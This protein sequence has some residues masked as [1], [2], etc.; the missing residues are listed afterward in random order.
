M[1]IQRSTVLCA[2]LLLAGALQV[3][4]VSGMSSASLSLV[5]QATSDTPSGSAFAAASGRSE[6]GSIDLFAFASAETVQQAKDEIVSIIKRI[7]DK[8]PAPPSP[9]DKATYCPD[10]VQF[11]EVEAKAIGVAGAKVTVDVVGEVVIE[12]QG[13]GCADSGASAEAFAISFASLFVDAIVET[14]ING[15][16]EA[17]AKAVL[18]AK[19][20][21]FAAAFASATA[22][23]CL[24]GPG[25]SVAEQTVTAEALARPVA[26]ILVFLEAFVDCSGFTETFAEA[27]VGA[28]LEEVITNV[29]ADGF[30]RVD[31]Q[32]AADTT[33]DAFAITGR[34]CSGSFDRCCSRREGQELPNGGTCFCTI[35]NREP[36]RATPPCRAKKTILQNGSVFFTNEDDT[37]CAC[38]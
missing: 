34:V 36:R 5:T 29:S 25:S 23:A 11:V 8:V 21:A 37:S 33:A 12:G 27:E 6:G 19:S 13:D 9:L 26:S 18:S 16:D 38:A 20:N 14:G 31:G 1:A 17:T 32:G 3:S 35:R 24:D 10:V 7:I 28:V 2:A 30:S 15:I 22:S 4:T